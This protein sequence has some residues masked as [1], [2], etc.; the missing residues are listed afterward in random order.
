[1]STADDGK[2]H[3]PHRQDSTAEPLTVFLCGPSKCEHDYSGWQDIV[4]DG[5]VR[6]GTAVC[7][8]CGRSAIDEAAWL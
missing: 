7:S 2:K 8:K 6:G 3:G 1:M 4:V 5:Q